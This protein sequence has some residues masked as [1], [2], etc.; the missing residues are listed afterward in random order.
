VARSADSE[1]SFEHEKSKENINLLSNHPLLAYVYPDHCAKIDAAE[2][3]VF[4]KEL[5]AIELP[6]QKAKTSGQVDSSKS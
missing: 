5:Q 2:E 4:S 3:F 1:V 6:F